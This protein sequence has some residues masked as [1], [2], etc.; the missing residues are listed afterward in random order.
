MWA[1]FFTI[2]MASGDEFFDDTAVENTGAPQPGGEASDGEDDDQVVVQSTDRASIVPQIA[3]DEREH[4][5]S[6]EYCG[7]AFPP[8]MM[9]NKGTSEHPKWVDKPCHG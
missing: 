9:L 5:V 7:F 6:C 1:E 4:W 8:F 2:P 3:E